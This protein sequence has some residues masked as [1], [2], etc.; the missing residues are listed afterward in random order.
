MRIALVLVL[1]ACGGNAKQPAPA[2][3]PAQTSAT[4]TSST[5]TNEVP[6][7]PAPP[8]SP[9]A[10]D[11]A[12]T[13]ELETSTAAAKPGSQAA[14]A[15]QRNDEGKADME[16]G[17]Y[18]DAAAKFREAVAR[19]PDPTYFFNLCA[20]LYQ[21]GRFAEAL[22]ACNAIANNAPTAA[23]M[24]KRDKMIERILAEA[25]RQGVSLQPTE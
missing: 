3:P 8:R 25:K 13:G 11:P 21:Q 16:A 10:E 17:K 23:L 12:V 22:T 4:Q 14:I 20:A 5:Q 9:P 7:P 2:T 1:A 6:P 15:K 24:A 18:G 19:V